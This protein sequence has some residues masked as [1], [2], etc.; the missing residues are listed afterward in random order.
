MGEMIEFAANGH[1][2]RGYL[3]TPAS[4]S[5]P[6]V[7]VLQ[8]WWGLAPQLMRVADRLAV[9][10]YTALAPDLYHGELAQHDEM[11]K[12]AHLMTTLDQQRAAQDMT[13]AIDALSANDACSSAK[14]GVIGFCM[15]GMLT[16]RLCALAGDRVASAAPVYGA[17]LGADSIDWSHLRAKIRGHFASND[18]F[19]PPDACLALAEHLR[20]LGKDVEFTVYPNTGHPFANED[21]PFGTYD[22]A[23]ARA[24]WGATLALFAAEIA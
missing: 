3:T 22:E 17:P 23:A 15:G 5:G 9:E 16:M 4:G 10:G 18:D 24:A 13:G 14:V 8:E 19:F 1:T 2:A 7:I 12:A 11:D 20:G 21:D 6:G